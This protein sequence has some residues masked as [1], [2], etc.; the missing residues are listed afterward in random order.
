M[1]DKVIVP[2][3]FDKWFKEIKQRY[4]HRSESATKF[5]M[6][7]ISEYGFCC[8]LKNADEEREPDE[9][10]RHWVSNNYY[11][12]A[13]AILDGYTVENPHWVLELPPEEDS[14]TGYIR[15]VSRITWGSN[16]SKPLV[17]DFTYDDTE[18]LK[19][20]NKDLADFVANV[21]EED[22]LKVYEAGNG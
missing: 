19:I 2:K 20:P 7:K 11:I 1:V 9:T 15:W 21:W 8:T 18:A 5:A 22:S 6:W 13:R 16:G 10:L 14:G 4:P 17:L 12:A 3:A